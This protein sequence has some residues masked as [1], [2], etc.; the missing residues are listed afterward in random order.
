EF[1]TDV[2][3]VMWAYI[4]RKKKLP[5]TTLLRALG[6]SLNEDIVSLFDLAE[7]T[8]VSKKGLEALIGRRLAAS[9]TVEK[10]V[11]V[12]DEDTGE[13]VSERTEREVILPAEHV[14]AAGDYD[15]L[16]EAGVSKIFIIPEDKEEE[17]DKST[18]LNT[19]RKDPAHSEAEAL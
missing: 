10:T 14:L 15:K 8:K 11:E 9:V 2:S 17:V 1:S 6:Y 12:V 18:L 16:K 7:E 3:N 19:M 5:V 13:V 4:D